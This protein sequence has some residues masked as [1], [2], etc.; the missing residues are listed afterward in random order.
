[1]AMVGS[2]QN[3]MVEGGRPRREAAVGATMAPEVA[4]WLDPSGA[5]RAAGV[6]KEAQ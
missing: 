2:F 5:M 1:M 4:E 6:V 3:R